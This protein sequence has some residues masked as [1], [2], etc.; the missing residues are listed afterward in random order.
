[1]LGLNWCDFGFMDMSMVLIVLVYVLDVDDFYLFHLLFLNVLFLMDVVMIVIDVIT[2][3]MDVIEL[4][5]L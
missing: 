2:I 5:V 4:F 3:L 1:M